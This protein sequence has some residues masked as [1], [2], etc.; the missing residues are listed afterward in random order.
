MAHNNKQMRKEFWIIGMILMITA[1]CFSQTK[2]GDMSVRL[3]YPIPVGHHFV[4]K[5]FE[6]GYIGI[7]NI[8]IDYCFMKKQHF[9]FDLILDAGALI[10]PKHEIIGAAVSPKIG[11]GY[12][13][14]LDNISIV[15]HIGVG[16]AYWRFSA[17]ER[18]FTD[19]Y[20]NLIF[21]EKSRIHHHGL[22]LRSGL[23]FIFNSK[24]KFQWFIHFNYDFTR[25]FL[26]DNSTTDNSYNRNIQ[27][28]YPGI[29]LIYNFNN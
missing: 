11:M 16:Y 17:P 24:D 28:F 26:L 22:T 5:G 2:T 23:K 25:L 29:G 19:A 9:V 21:E 14:D 20:G 4:N 10:L 27:I 7:A 3:D 18:T 6:T 8:G 12:H 1:P 13:L 15:P